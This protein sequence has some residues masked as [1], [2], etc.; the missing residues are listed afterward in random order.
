MWSQDTGCSHRRGGQE[1]TAWSRGPCP[2][3][4]PSGGS[5]QRRP[6]RSSG[7]APTARPGVGP[8]SCAQ[9]SSSSGSLGV[10]S[11][12]QRK[13]L[14]EKQALRVMAARQEHGLL[15]S[16]SQVCPAD[17]VSGSLWCVGTGAGCV[18][19]T[20]CVYGVCVGVR[21]HTCL[22]GFAGVSRCASAHVCEQLRV[23]L[24]DVKSRV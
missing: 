7:P 8:P 14:L 18:I 19:C 3:P 13:V 12:I 20:W 1:R 15:K 4:R 11:Y 2:G 21:A 10:F 22:C 16:S 9:S 24:F 23:C 5:S 17:G 6:G